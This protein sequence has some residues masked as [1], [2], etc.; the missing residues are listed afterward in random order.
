M[1]F[2]ELLYYLTIRPLEILF[3]TIFFISY[4]HIGKPFYTIVALSIFVNIL[5]FPLYKRA[6]KLQ[7]EQR[8]REKSMEGMLSHIK[9]TFK[10]DEKVMM[11][12]AYYRVCDYNPVYALRGASSLLLQIPFFIAAYRFL[13]S[14]ELIKGLPCIL[15][16]LP[17]RGGVPSYLINDLGSPDGMLFAFGH[18][19]NVLPILMTLINIVSGT[20]YS[21]GHLRKE[22]IQLYVTALV[23]LVLLY[24][25]PSGLVIY[26]TCNNIFSLLKNFVQK[27]FERGK[28]KSLSYNQDQMCPALPQMVLLKHITT[29]SL[30]Q[31]FSCPLSRDFSSL[32]MSCPHLQR[33]SSVLLMSLILQSIWFIL[34][35]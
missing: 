28:K 31:P 11:T 22:K 10:G 25:S 33:N 30:L 7:S 29:S 17:W 16:T 32:R 12:Q 27:I 3:E 8:M 4:R 23:F 26:W 21:K 2:L 18:S 24:N 20:I 13:S 14:L 1:F 6:D 15:L 19:V 34:W 5:V 9:K 35:L